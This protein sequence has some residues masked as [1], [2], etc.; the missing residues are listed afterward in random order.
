MSRWNLEL[1]LWVCIS[2]WSCASNCCA[3][4]FTLAVASHTQGAALDSFEWLVFV[5]VCVSVSLWLVA[6]WVIWL[7]G[8]ASHSPRRRRRIALKIEL[9]HE[10]RVNV[11]LDSAVHLILEICVFE[12]MPQ[13]AWQ[14]MFL[15]MFQCLKTCDCLNVWR[16][17]YARI[18]TRKNPLW[19][20]EY[21]GYVRVSALRH[22]H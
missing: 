14:R 22:T 20:P 13:E 19:I 9:N 5:R 2:L 17:V 21:S 4:N 16:L 12:S 3:L 15:W 10:C 1:W 7:S 8:D 6:L 18:Q 11:Q